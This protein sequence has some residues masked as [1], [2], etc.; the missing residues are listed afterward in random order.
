MAVK[1]KYHALGDDGS[2]YRVKDTNGTEYAVFSLIDAPKHAPRACKH[3]NIHIPPHIEE[4]IVKNGD[5]GLLL[6]IYT[7]VLGIIYLNLQ[8]LFSLLEFPFFL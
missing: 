4:E 3:M 1:F 5:V 8:T 6:S 2:W 7:F